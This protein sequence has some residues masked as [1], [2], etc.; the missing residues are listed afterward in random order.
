MISEM[1]GFAPGLRLEDDRAV[2]MAASTPTT[3]S[4]NLKILA[5][6]IS[7]VTSMRRTCLRDCVIG[8][9]IASVK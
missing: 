8:T 5:V 4:S 9:C 3:S 2:V 1:E 7:H 6:N